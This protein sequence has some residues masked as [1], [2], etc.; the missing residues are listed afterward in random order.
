MTKTELINTVAS[1]H[2][3]PLDDRVRAT[4]ALSL[5]NFTHV[6][7]H[8]RSHSALSELVSWANTKE[9]GSFWATIHNHLERN[10]L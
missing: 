4:L 5:H 7:H 10:D 3:I 1:C 2:S 8:T 9:G 6:A